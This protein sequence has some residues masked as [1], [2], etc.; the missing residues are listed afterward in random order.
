MVEH[1][2]PQLSIFARHFKSS[3]EASFDPFL[4]VFILSLD[5]QM[6]TFT[7]VKPNSLNNWCCSFSEGLFCIKCKSAICFSEKDGI[8]WK[9]ICEDIERTQRYRVHKTPNLVKYCPLLGILWTAG[10]SGVFVFGFL[11]SLLFLF[12]YSRVPSVTENWYWLLTSP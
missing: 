12:S 3:Q 8:Y 5:F 7:A 9:Y 6:T 10:S 2:L 11:F 4:R 1:K